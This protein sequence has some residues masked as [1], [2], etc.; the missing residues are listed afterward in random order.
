[1]VSEVQKDVQETT[2]QIELLESSFE[3]IAPQAN[4][5]VTSFYGNLFTD[6]PAAKPLFAHS[7]MTEQGNKL[8]KSLVFVVENL[9]QPEALAGALK[10][11]GARHVKYGALPEHYPLVGNTLLKTFEQYLG[12]EW[13][14]D[15]RQA[16]AG[17]YGVITEVMLEGADYSKTQV[18]LD[19]PEPEIDE[20]T[21]LKVRLLE[22]SFE[23]VKP[24][25]NEFVTS[26]YENL[27]TD[28]PAAKPLFAHTD[29]SD[30][31]RKLLT[32]LVFVV[33][34]L[35]K[36]GALTG[37]LKGLGARHVKYGALPEHYPLV[38]NTLLK[39]FGQYLKEDWTAE[40]QQ[41]WVDA[42]GLITTVML[43]GAEY[44]ETAVQLQ[45]SAATVEVPES[46]I[47]TGTA[48]GLIGGG[49]IAL[50]ALFL[51]V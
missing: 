8:L 38:G 24:H 20:A 35:R 41:A 46:N 19:S 3:K 43:E 51:L 39:T 5:F 30:Q 7:N 36:P 32:S 2:L 21:G 15:T 12:D 17:A 40:T 49:L 37:A 25:A 44:D 6:Y 4:E 10:G 27:F 26:F 18:Q 28:Y 48:A 9:R 34:N 31:G 14:P 33:E 16:W 42:Y 50:V 45:S 13:T 1:M 23:K 22:E 29:M 11:L 47:T